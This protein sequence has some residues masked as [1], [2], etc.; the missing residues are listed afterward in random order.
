[1]IMETFSEK[2]QMRSKNLVCLKMLLGFTGPSSRPTSTPTSASSWP[3][4]IAPWRSAC[5][6]MLRDAT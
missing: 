6:R 4:V 5:L 3:W 1:M 2:L